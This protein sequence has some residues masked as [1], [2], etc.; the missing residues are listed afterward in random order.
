MCAEKKKSH[1]SHFKLLR[2]LWTVI[3]LK[4]SMD[5]LLHAFFL[6]LL[7]WKA[8]G[9]KRLLV[10]LAIEKEELTSR[11]VIV[12]VT[13]EQ[14]RN[15]GIC[16][17]WLFLVARFWVTICNS[18][19]VCQPLFDLLAAALHPRADTC[20][21]LW[22]IYGNIFLLQNF[23]LIFAVCFCIKMINERPPFFRDTDTSSPTA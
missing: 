2:Q 10:N 21:K 4:G 9:V 1:D 22:L 8:R 11:I 7:W 17:V 18:F 13:T 3:S 15:K 5:I 12:W 14:I 23:L 16:H 19:C 20:W 6:M